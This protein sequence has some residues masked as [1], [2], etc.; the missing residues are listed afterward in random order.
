[1]KNMV[2]ISFLGL[3]AC[4]A[5]QCDPNHTDLFTGIGCSA[6]GYQDR[7]DN[8]KH[9]YANA[10]LEEAEQ[11][12]N[13]KTAQQKAIAAQQALATRRTE[14]M[15][16]DQQAWQLRK[17][18]RSAQINHEKSASVQ[19]EQARLNKFDHVRAHTSANPTQQELDHLSSIL[20]SI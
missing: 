18:L 12:K 2:G 11:Q 13:A 3:A 4:S 20:G 5:Q 7:T 19:A 16:I 8:L 14:L 6:R 1:M 15:K 9:T 17:R 10:K